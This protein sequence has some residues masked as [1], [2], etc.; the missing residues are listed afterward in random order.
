[1]AGK[2]NA[3]SHYAKESH[4]ENSVPTVHV[5]YMFM[6]SSDD[7]QDEDSSDQGMPI[8]VMHDDKTGMTFSTVVPQKGVHPYA[9]V[10]VSNDLSILGHEKIILKSDGEPAIKA[11]KE[12]VQADS[13]MKIEITKTR[14][15]S[16]SNYQGRKSCV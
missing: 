9:S 14:R 3:K 13:S 4:E 1:M 8:L 16:G 6:N 10:R 2:A 11:L 5:D 12:A 7:K 15:T